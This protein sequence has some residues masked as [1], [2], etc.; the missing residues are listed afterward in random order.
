MNIILVAMVC[1]A[2][3]QSELSSSFLC[4]KLSD[5]FHIPFSLVS[6]SA[7]H[8][9]AYDAAGKYLLLIKTLNAALIN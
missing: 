3:L 5:I 9:I 2:S 4:Y 6:W 8:N 1:V 7:F